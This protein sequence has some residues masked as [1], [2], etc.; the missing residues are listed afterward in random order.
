LASPQTI[1]F[2][3]LSVRSVCLPIL[4]DYKHE[5]WSCIIIWYRTGSTFLHKRSQW[6]Y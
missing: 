2:F 3:S 4:I 5:W 1:F 6:H